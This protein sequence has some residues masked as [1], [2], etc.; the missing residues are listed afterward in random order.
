MSWDAR[1]DDRYAL[2]EA[3]K[4][5]SEN[6]NQSSKYLVIFLVPVAQ[7]RSGSANP[8]VVPTEEVKPETN[9]GL[10]PA[11]EVKPEDIGTLSLRYVDGVPQLVVNGGTHA[12]AQLVLVNAEGATVSVYQG[13][14]PV[15]AR[16][17]TDKPFLLPIEEVFKI[18]ER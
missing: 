7:A 3:P 12:P 11:T 14:P 1:L 16:S 5:Q 15:Q 6:L 13:L 4:C 9:L 2:L 18:A 10:I 17:V 8:V